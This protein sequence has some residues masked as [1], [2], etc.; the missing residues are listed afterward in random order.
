MSTQVV[1]M[2][3]HNSHW[4]TLT[5]HIGTRCVRLEGLALQLIDES[6]SISQRRSGK[7]DRKGLK[8][9]VYCSL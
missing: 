4:P 9:G 1:E 6:G 5:N 8:D 2:Y 7:L 3:L